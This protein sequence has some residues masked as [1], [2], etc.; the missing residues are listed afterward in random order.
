MLR[1]S[2]L[3]E[4]RAEIAGRAALQAG[5]VVN[6]IKD[7]LRDRDREALRPTLISQREG[8]RVGAFHSLVLTETRLLR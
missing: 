8:A 6:P 3:K 4:I 1:L 7:L 5:L 2:L